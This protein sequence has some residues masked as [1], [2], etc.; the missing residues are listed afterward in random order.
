[1]RRRGKEGEECIQVLQQKSSYLNF[2]EFHVTLNMRRSGEVPC[3]VSCAR[4]NRVPRRRRSLH[5]SG[6]SS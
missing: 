5:R 2:S 6:P 3:G 4:A 1:V